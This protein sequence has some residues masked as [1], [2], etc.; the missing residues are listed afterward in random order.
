MQ[1]LSAKLKATRHVLL[2]LLV[3][4]VLRFYV[5]WL[6]LQGSERWPAAHLPVLGC[7]AVNTA[8]F[9]NT[10]HPL[11]VPAAVAAARFVDLGVNV[12]C[13]YSKALAGADS[14]AQQ[15]H[16]KALQLLL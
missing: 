6:L 16:Q 1:L 3:M 12:G 2:L 9:S 14:K 10:Q 7:T 4:A 8:A 11:L 5:L 13:S 15:C